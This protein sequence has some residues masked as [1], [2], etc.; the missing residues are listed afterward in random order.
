MLVVE[1]PF[2]EFCVAA[3]RPARKAPTPSLVLGQ[4]PGSTAQE[5]HDLGQVASLS[6]GFLLCH[7]DS[8]NNCLS[9]LKEFRSQC[10]LRIE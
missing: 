9:H 3:V 1:G 7:W 5:L 2:K 8:N 10:L 6:L 4:S